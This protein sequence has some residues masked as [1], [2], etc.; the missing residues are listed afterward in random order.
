MVPL[1]HEGNFLAM[2]FHEVIVD[3]LVAWGTLVLPLVALVVF[4]TISW[5]NRNK[6]VIEKV[7]SE[8]SSLAKEFA[9][10]NRLVEA[11]IRKVVAAHQ[12]LHEAAGDLNIFA[13][14][15]PQI[16]ADEVALQIPSE[17]F[18]FILKP[19]F[20]LLGWLMRPPTVRSTVYRDRDI[21][22]LRA[23]VYQRGQVEVELE[24]VRRQTSIDNLKDELAREL[25]LK[26]VIQLSLSIKVRDWRAIDCL[27]RAIQLWP[28]DTTQ[29][30]QSDLQQEWKAVEE[31]LLAAKKYDP[32]NVLVNY[33]LGLFHYYRY[34]ATDNEKA[35]LLFEQAGRTKSIRLRG[36][37]KKGVAR[38]YCQDYHRFGKESQTVL[39]NARST[40]MEAVTLIEQ[41]KEE[42]KGESANLLK[43]DLARALY[44]RAFAYHVTERPEDIDRAVDDYRQVIAEIQPAVVPAF[45]YNNLGYIL[46]AKAGRFKVDGSP[47]DYEEA[48]GYLNE[49]LATN[50][51]YKFALANLGNIERIL[52]SYDKAIRHYREAVERIDPGYA[53]G[54]NELAWVY[55]ANGQLN[56]AMDAHGKALSLA[57]DDGHRGEVKELYARALN[58]V[59]RH[60]EALKTARE[61]LILNPDNTTVVE[62]LAEIE[63]QMPGPRP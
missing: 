50:P 48:Q 28:K 57:R 24:K 6:V 9:D 36:L 11:E 20:L 37:A 45:I 60:E 10:L 54:W 4:V 34:N 12:T 58:S 14:V 42:A 31:A 46:M 41:A 17:K 53:N 33:N 30:S 1:R 5:I 40:A 18:R 26:L 35:R 61:A 3:Q 63:K 59:G 23:T 25:A 51:A 29:V 55:L 13:H 38:T 16:K 32:Y 22:S 7:K 8:D 21:I 15:A 62:L 52:R 47:S 43:I 44:C 49:A 39:S 2:A 56:E 19:V 27:T